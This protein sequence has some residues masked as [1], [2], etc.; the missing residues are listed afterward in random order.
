MFTPRILV[1]SKAKLA[2]CQLLT[3]F[4]VCI[5]DSKEATFYTPQSVLFLVMRP[6][7]YNYALNIMKVL[8]ISR[9]IWSALTYAGIQ[10]C[11]K[12]KCR[13]NDTPVN[14]YARIILNWHLLTK[15][16]INR[17][18]HE[19]KNAKVGALPSNSGNIFHIT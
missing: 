3:Y 13:V 1:N 11:I 2:N 10:L 8:Q 17:N 15:L 7:F 16:I 12:Y 19:Y 14:N 4:Q 9:E 18:W 6:P 5:P